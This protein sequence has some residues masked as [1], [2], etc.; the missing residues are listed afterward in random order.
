MSAEPLLA[1]PLLPAQHLDDPGLPE[2]PFS[3]RE[4][5]INH[6]GGEGIPGTSSPSAEDGGLSAGTT[7][8]L[9][10]ELHW[11]KAIYFLGCLGGT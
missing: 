11:M 6:A 8:A 7:K 10:Q 2:Q 4:V 5:T 1:E 9:Y 3:S